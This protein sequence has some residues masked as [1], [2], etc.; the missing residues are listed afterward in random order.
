MLLWDYFG[1]E[2][3]GIDVEDEDGIRM[4]SK[5][6]HN[7]VNELEWMMKKRKKDVVTHYYYK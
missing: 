4:T 5:E 7:I 1:G 2:V 3:V 6:Q